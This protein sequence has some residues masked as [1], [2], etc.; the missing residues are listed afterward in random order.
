MANKLCDPG[1][2]E[3]PDSYLVCGR[4]SNGEQMVPVSRA[5]K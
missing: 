1:D 4:W 5:C 2:D 3:N